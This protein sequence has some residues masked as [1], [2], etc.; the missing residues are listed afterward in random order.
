MVS[1]SKLRQLAGKST[2]LI[3]TFWEMGASDP[4]I[5]LYS[6]SKTYCLRRRLELSTES[7]AVGTPRAQVKWTSRLARGHAERSVSIATVVFRWFGAR[8][9]KR[10]ARVQKGAPKP[11]KGPKRGQDPCPAGRADMVAKPGAILHVCLEAFLGRVE[12]VCGE[13]EHVLHL[14]EQ[15]LTTTVLREEPVDQYGLTISLQISLSEYIWICLRWLFSI[16]WRICVFF[17]PASMLK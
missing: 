15:Y 6:Y 2:I 4:G 3:H 1:T 5:G 12:H 14:K 17:Q 16:T 7:V 9:I 8:E 10:G 11:K 13:A